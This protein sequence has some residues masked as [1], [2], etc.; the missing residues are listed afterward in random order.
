M[1]E[2]KEKVSEPIQ[3]K[4]LI[5]A[6][7]PRT[8]TPY[9][10]QYEDIAVEQGYIYDILFWDRFQNAA[11][12]KVGNEYTLHRVCTLGGSKLKKIPAMI[13]FRKTLKQIIEKGKYDR[14][15]IL[16]TLPGILLSDILLEKFESRYILDIRDYTYEKYGFYRNRVNQLIDH[17]F[18]STI[19]SMGFY[20]F[21]RR[22]KTKKIFLNHNISNVSEA[23]NNCPDFKHKRTWNIGFVGAVRYEEENEKLVSAFANDTKFEVSYYGRFNE[24]C[25]LDRY[26]DKKQIKNVRF[27]GPFFNEEKPQIY[28]AV[29]I[30]NSLYG[31]KSTDVLFLLPNRLYDCALFKKPIIVSGGTYLSEVVKKYNLGIVIE[32]YGNIKENVIQYIENFVPNEFITNCRRLLMDVETDSGL[33][34]NQLKNFFR[35]ESVKCLE[36]M[37]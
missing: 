14:I 5:V 35:E 25:H 34:R 7:H 13:Y 2:S 37:K 8:M 4:A 6:F 22:E 18:I 28:K 17:S 10:R 32:D 31:G 15:V 19:S 33:L 11:L 20:H 21:L 1:A 16:N 23:W 29:D 27:N 26:C 9:S 36:N 12:D 30:I 24:G 3:R